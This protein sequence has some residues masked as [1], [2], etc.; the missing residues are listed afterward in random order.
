M[1][2]KKNSKKA[3]NSPMVQRLGLSAF[4]AR[5]LSLIPG[6]GTKILQAKQCDRKK[7]SKKA[8]GILILQPHNTFFT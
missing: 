3:G 4:T 1:V 6:W 2:I 8:I 7:K 5:G